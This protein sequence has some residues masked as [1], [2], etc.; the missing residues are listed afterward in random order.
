MQVRLDGSG[1]PV[2]LANNLSLSAPGLMGYAAVHQPQPAR[3]RG[4]ALGTETLEEA[5]KQAGWG[6]Q[7]TVELGVAA[8][9]GPPPAR[10][11]R[12][13]G[14]LAALQLEVA[15]PGPAWGT[16]VLSQDETGAL[17]WHFPLDQQ[18]RM[19][20]P[21]RGGGSRVFRIPRRVVQPPGDGKPT[22]GL[23]GLLGKKL[24]KVLVYPVTDPVLGAVSE[25]FARRWEEA[26]R[27]YGVRHFGPDTYREARA[28]LADADWQRLQRGRSL[29]FIHG[30]FSRAVSAFGALPAET[31]TAL[32]DRYQGRV[33]AFDHHTLSQSPEANC[34]QLLQLMPPGAA[35]DVDI[36]CHSR[37]G[38]V[39]RT[40]AEQFGALKA[41]G[42]NIRVGKVVFVASP[43]R[44]T[45]LADPDHMTQMLDRYTSALNLFPAVSL[46]E[47]LDGLLAV[48]KVLGHGALKG[49]DGLAAMH[50]R[51]V[52]LN[53]ETART[54]L[55]YYALTADFDAGKAGLANL[56]YRKEPAEKGR[57]SV[58]G[59]VADRVLDDIFR[60]DANDL[61]VPTE[62]VYAWNGNP[63]FPIPEERI[64]RFIQTTS[65]SH[66]N[67]FEHGETSAKLLEWLHG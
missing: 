32:A 27:P 67:F 53:V 55:E 39:A 46:V 64:H 51:R 15:D 7:A 33:W 25:L 36:V 14:D 20:P 49:L 23:I 47:I 4:P 22:R 45:L 11:V 19:A 57:V 24:L 8:M 56:V 62:G 1:Q 10:D 35:L 29:L 2:R 38:L 34:N 65:V 37:G 54:G 66:V 42:R 6:E 9:P 17:S 28:P 13:P 16:V 48:V 5:L 52:A 63:N 60:Q 50:P 12:A 21:T 43:N 26:N 3:T 61:V 40:L 58:G 44:G 41:D 30:T 31:M 18:N 59:A